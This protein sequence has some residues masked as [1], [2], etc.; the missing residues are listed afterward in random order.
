MVKGAYSSTAVYSV[1]DLKSLNN[2]ANDRGVRLFLEIDIPGHAGSWAAGYPEIMADCLDYYTNINNY[3]LNPTLPETYDVVARV[4][5]DVIETTGVKTFH[6]G[7]D[8]VVYGCWDNDASIKA[9]MENKGWTNYDDLLEYFVL[10]VD[11]IAKELGATPVHWNEVFTANVDVEPDTIFEVWTDQSQ[12]ALIADANFTIISAPSDVWYLDHADNT[13]DVMY[14]YDPT[15]DLSTSQKP[16]VLGGEVAMWGEHVDENNVES[17]VYPRA[18]SVGE[19]LWSPAEVNSV[20]AAKDRFNL[21]RCRMIQRGFHP[22][23]IEPGYCSQSL[24]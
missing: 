3:A 19:R 24:V 22:S 17:I 6:L 15:S 8:E 14:Q 23:A 1:E 4:M 21:Q 7:G 20:D 9:F 18:N 11:K 2:Y 16:L 13:W 10:K 5:K 12:M